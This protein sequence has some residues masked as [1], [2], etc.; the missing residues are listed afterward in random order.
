MDGWMDGWIRCL[1]PFLIIKSL[2]KNKERAARGIR[3]AVAMAAAI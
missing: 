2:Y 3:F 1:L